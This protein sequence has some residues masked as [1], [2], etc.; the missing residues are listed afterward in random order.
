MLINLRCIF[1]QFINKKAHFK[2]SHGSN[3]G[4]IF[5]ILAL[6]TLL[7]SCNSKEPTSQLE[8][9]LNRGQLTIVTRNSPTTYYEAADGYAGVE[10][11]LAKQFAKSLGVDLKFI[12]KDN[13]KEIKDLLVSG[14]VDFAAAGLTITSERKKTLR[15]APAYQKVSSKLVFKQGAKWPRNI[16]QLNGELRVSAHSSHSQALLKLKQTTPTLHWSETTEQ[17]SEELLMMVLD[18]TIDYTVVDSTELALNRRFHPELMVAFT[19]GKPQK[20]AWAFAKK[21]DDSLFSKAIEFFGQQHV[22]GKI[23]QLDEKYYGHVAQFD[24]LDTRYFQQASKNKL[25]HYKDH[26]VGSAGND[27]DWRLL[28]AVS[29]QESH[30]NP[31][32]K[33]PTG[34]RGMMMLTQNTAKQLGISDRLNVEQSIYGGAKYLRRMMKRM[35]Q[36]IQEPDRTWF[37]LASYN[38]GLGHVEDARI[39]TEKQGFDPN[40]WSDVKQHLPLLQKKK[41]YKQT[42]HGYARGR[43][44]VNYVNNIRRYYEMLVWQDNQLE[45]MPIQVAQTDEDFQSQK[46]EK[47]LSKLESSKQ[48]STQQKETKELALFSRKALN[49]K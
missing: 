21:Q 14:K 37:A 43:E 16:S 44:P 22:E 35:P 39:I 32:A 34:V 13:L 42:K 2:R 28:A 9:V 17:T 41:W 18:G 38:V 26:F 29:Y 23:A 1:T 49:N 24:Y 30:W 25:T 15:F 6:S 36:G 7:I 40:K 12:V 19:L 48:A 8:E 3:A 46:S 5:A 45:E 27:L 10:Y 20:L 47:K 11:E 31:K 33:S 4:F